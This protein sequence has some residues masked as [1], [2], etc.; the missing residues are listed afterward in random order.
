M[1]SSIDPLSNDP[2]F[3][4]HCHKPFEQWE[5][6]LRHKQQRRNDKNEDHIH[7]KICARDFKT[8]AGEMQHMQVDH[9]LEQ[10]LECPGCG[11][12]PFTRLSSLIDHIERGFC[13]RLDTAVLDQLREEK[14][15]FPR[16]LEQLTREK[17]K[18]NYMS[19]MPSAAAN[20]IVSAWHVDK[21]PEAFEMVQEEF[22]AL[23]TTEDTRTEPTKAAASNKLNIHRDE[24]NDEKDKQPF[25]FQPPVQQAVKRVDTMDIDTKHKAQPQIELPLRLLSDSKRNAKDGPQS[26]SQASTQPLQNSTQA[27]ARPLQNSTQASTRP[28]FKSGVTTVVAG[29]DP[30]DPN[31]PSF[32]AASCYCSIT[33][34]FNCPKRLCGKTFKTAGGLIGHLKSPFH[35]NRKYRCP[36]CLKIFKSLTGIT[37]HAEAKGSKCPI[38]DTA[39]YETFMDQLTAGIVDIKRTRYQ[40][41]SIIYK[42]SEQMKQKLRGKPMKEKNKNPV[43]TIDDKDDYW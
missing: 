25:S 36:S 33:E 9:P 39:Q 26:S 12:G 21:E 31:N 43:V 1:D 17:V 3:C 34:R 8:L 19:Y 2:L 11:R 23:V 37:S 40:G 28:A 10:N 38:Q 41:G 42:T 14:L 20:S 32:S 5:D 16:R 30:D 18:G 29:M 22:P 6:L 24:T 7:C 4:Y 15:E 13:P 35:G 27:S